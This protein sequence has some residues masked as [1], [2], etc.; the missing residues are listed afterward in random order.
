[1]HTSI[2][3]V[4]P[5][6]LIQKT[7]E[8]VA[9]GRQVPIQVTQSNNKCLDANVQ[10]VCGCC[11]QNTRIRIPI[12]GEPKQRTT[13]VTVLKAQK[14]EAFNFAYC[15]DFSTLH[16][17]AYLF[18]TA[19]ETVFQGFVFGLAEPPGATGEGARFARIV[20]ALTVRPLPDVHYTYCQTVRLRP[21]PTSN[22]NGEPREATRGTAQSWRFVRCGPLFESEVR[23]L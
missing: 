14:I 17:A 13:R 23:K 18:Y 3:T 16:R 5:K 12:R 15:R 19:P 21:A 6:P 10:A 7:L 22:G 8:P 11:V 20:I 9:E 4:G 2:M 1:M